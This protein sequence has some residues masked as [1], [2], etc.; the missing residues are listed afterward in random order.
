MQLVSLSLKVGSCIGN[1]QLQNSN[2][3]KTSALRSDKKSLGWAG[4]PGKAYGMAKQ[5]C[6]VSGLFCDISMAFDADPFFYKK[7]RIIH[8]RLQL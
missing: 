5:K 2:R 7:W 4:R 1:R 8:I 3:T 6:T